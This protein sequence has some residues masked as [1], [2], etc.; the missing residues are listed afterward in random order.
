MCVEVDVEVDYSL[1]ICFSSTFNRT[2]VAS[3]RCRWWSSVVL[4]ISLGPIIALYLVWLPLTCMGKVKAADVP[5]N[6]AF[7]RPSEIIEAP[8]P[9]ERMHTEV[10]EQGGNAAAEAPNH[11][12]VGHAL[13][14]QH[15]H[16]HQ[17]HQQ[18][19]HLEAE[20]GGGKEGNDGHQGT[21]QNVP[22]GDSSA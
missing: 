3:H 1:S 10:A 4:V 2:K 18:Q 14:Q 5:E 12:T 13:H 15:Q 8:A 9:Q 19:S 21:M 6:E 22:F 11:G 17:H 20:R 7:G 16:Q